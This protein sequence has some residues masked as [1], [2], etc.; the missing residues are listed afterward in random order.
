MPALT[1]NR[2][3]NGFNG[4]RRLKNARASV[5]CRRT[6]GAVGSDANRSKALVGG[7]GSTNKS[8]RRAIRRRA[9]TGDGLYACNRDPIDIVLTNYKSIDRYT[10]DN[11]PTYTFGSNYVGTIVSNYAFLSSNGVANATAAK[12]NNNSITFN[13]LAD[14]TYSNVWIY[15]KDTAGNLSNK[16]MVPTFTINTATPTVSYVTSTTADGTY[17]FGN[18]INISV[19]FSEI[20]EVTGTP[21]IILDTGLNTTVNYI[22]GT[23]TN[24]LIFNYT[25]VSRNNS[26]DL[27]Y[28]ATNS[29]S[30]T[31]KSRG[32][33][34]A[35]LTLAAPGAANSLANNKAIVINTAAPTINQITAITTPDNDNTPNYVFSTDKPGTLTSTLNFTSASNITAIGSVTVTF[36]N[37][38][39]TGLPDATYS[40]EAITLTAASGDA[41]TVTI[42]IFKIDTVA[43]TLA[44][45]TQIRT[46]STNTTP[47]FLF[48]TTE[49]GNMVTNYAITAPG[50]TAAL[51]STAVSTGASITVTYAALT[52]QTYSN[53]YITVEDGAGNVSSQLG[54]DSFQ[55]ITTVTNTFTITAITG[56]YNITNTGGATTL[57]NNPTLTLQKGKLYEFD[58]R[59]G[60]LSGGIPTNQNHPF[61]IQDANGNYNFNLEHSSNVVDGTAQG[62]TSGILSFIV[63]TN[64]PAVLYYQC[65]AHTA[66]RG[67]INII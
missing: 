34:A 63:P 6:S 4:G 25:V 50:I 53:V 10:N 26:T 16:L 22:S 12:V 33:T 2:V 30:G 38:T 45:V 11:T 8:L 61:Q 5:K 23:G 54:V 17:Y 49:N 42:P 55:I 52:E 21:Q 40:G 47:S 13:T 9:Y 48:N 64:A 51:A 27:D 58:L 19:V 60:S 66:M 56:A 31:I 18:V 62:Q 59:D 20:V 1:H 3:K 15:V 44:S 46:P 28:S 29:L 36:N 43:P 35:N 39:G 37:A 32:G 41:T 24:T 7:I 14:G 67:T 57:G 65:S